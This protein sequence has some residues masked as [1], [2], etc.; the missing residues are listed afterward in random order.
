M[1]TRVIRISIGV[2]YDLSHEKRCCPGYGL[3]SE[4]TLCFGK[5]RELTM[6]RDG[7]RLD[8]YASVFLLVEGGG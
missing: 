7:A 8:D 4:M 5:I 6:K 1:N 2:M 3:N